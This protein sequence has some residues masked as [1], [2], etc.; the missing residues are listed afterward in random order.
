M[1][2]LRL[3]VAA[4]SLWRVCFHTSFLHV[5]LLRENLRQGHVYLRIILFLL[6]NNIPPPLHMR[7]LF[8]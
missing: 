1:S 8:I 7:I 2:R 3:S 6:I 5:G 4:I